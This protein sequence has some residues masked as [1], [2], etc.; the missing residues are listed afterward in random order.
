MEP[1]LNIRVAGIPPEGASFT[2]SISSD[3]LELDQDVEYS[4]FKDIE[5]NLYIQVVSERLIASGSLRTEVRFICARCAGAGSL[6]VRVD[7][8]RTVREIAD[9]PEYVDLTQDAREAIILAFPGYPVCRP[10]CK[11]L[12]SKCGK[13]LNEGK[14][15]CKPEKDSRWSALD[16]LEL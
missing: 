10:D 5:Y 14:C 8:F 7:D 2:G 3:V 11:G 4:S 12:C 9:D 16:D 6:E 13:N 1:A 15:G